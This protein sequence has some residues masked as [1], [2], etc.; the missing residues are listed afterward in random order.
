MT[1][2]AKGNVHSICNLSLRSIFAPLPFCAI[3]RLLCAQY[4]TSVTDLSPPVVPMGRKP[5]THSR[6]VPPCD[7]AVMQSNVAVD[8]QPKQ[9]GYDPVHVQLELCAG[10]GDLP[11]AARS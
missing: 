7:N 10:E 5:D 6:S 3:G 2:K 4:A 9:L 11:H 1:F 8:P